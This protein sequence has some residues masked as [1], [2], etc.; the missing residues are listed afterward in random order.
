MN[1]KEFAL[2]LKANG[3]TLVRSFNTYG[4]YLNGASVEDGAILKDNKRVGYWKAVNGKVLH[5]I[6]R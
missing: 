1:M 5:T 2:F 3:L 6:N 4:P